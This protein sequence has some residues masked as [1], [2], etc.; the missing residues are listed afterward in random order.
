MNSR[1]TAAP[2]PQFATGTFTPVRG[3]RLQCK[4]ACGGR[5]GPTGECEECGRKRLNLRRQFTGLEEPRLQHD[6][7]RIQ[8]HG[9]EP[10]GIQSKLVVGPPGD[11]YEREADR[12]AERIMRLPGSAAGTKRS[13]FAHHDSIIQR[14]RLKQ[15][16]DEQAAD[17]QSLEA[18]VKAV[19]SGGQPLPK[20]ERAFFEPR[21]GHDFGQVRVHTDTAAAATAQALNARAYTVERDIVFGAGQYA[22]GT[23][24]GRAL[25]AHELVHVVQQG[26]AS[27]A[28]KSISRPARQRSS[29]SVHAQR[30]LNPGTSSIR[31]ILPDGSEKFFRPP[32]MAASGAPPESETEIGE[33]Q[34][35]E[36]EAAR[37]EEEAPPRIQR[38]ATYPGALSI[39]QR[40]ATFTNPTPTAQDP[41]ARLATSQPPGLTTPT[42][43]SQVISDLQGVLTQI[44]PSRVAGT[45]GA[46][47]NVTCQFD[48]GFSIN[49]SANMIVASAAGA[50]GWVGTFP[51]A[52]LGNPAACAA[53]P[54]V[55][56]TMIAHPSNADFVTRVRAS[57]QEHVD[58]IRTLHNRHFVPYDRFVMGLSGTGANLS[59]CGQNLVS[60]LGARHT[61]GALGFVL[62]Y[63]A[64]TEKLDGPGGTHAD[65]ATPT[66]AAS[67]ASVTID[68]SQTTARI[69]GAGPGNVVTVAPTVTTFNPAQLT[70]VG[71]AVKEGNTVVKTFSNAANA[72][73]GLQ[74]I[75]HYGMTS[76]NVIGPMEF[77]LVGNSAPSGALAGANELAINPALY[78][79]TLN[80]PN[81]GDWAV[82]E[83]IGN[84]VNVLVNFGA[85]R[86]QAYSA[87]A[88]MTRLAFTQLCWVGGTRQSPEMLYFRT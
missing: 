1:S 9:A 17:A 7:S 21:F 37:P 61:Q 4:C 82:A 31:L 86:N 65:T 26:A 29:R 83:A 87:W 79:V 48:R 73:R 84:N 35:G 22:P 56:A 28:V 59:A 36:A 69:P 23:E 53:R 58:E 80:V 63:Q 16:S 34:A 38:M 39:L 76:R 78:Q 32:L 8:V 19:Q 44:S 75:Q 14:S 81:A 85:N 51:A 88:S 68:V 71:T 46:G 77:F 43:N 70:V 3:G 66:F 30:A 47:G 6:F 25:L 49:T 13:P 20:A 41:L 72:Q 24:G 33:P 15:E 18:Q 11:L 64:A 2:P 67:C 50:A 27:P 57:E 42:I 5:P 10:R 55:P 40:A 12:V 60:Q 54:N 52:A 74:V 62:G 45:G